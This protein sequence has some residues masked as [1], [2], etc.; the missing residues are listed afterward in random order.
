MFFGL[1]HDLLNYSVSSK[2]VPMNPLRYLGSSIDETC[3]TDSDLLSQ[4][5]A[6]LD[7][8]DLEVYSLAYD[9]RYGTPKDE[10]GRKNKGY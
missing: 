4:V 3:T 8:G 5:C 9:R 10:G 2:G 1:H 6:I 7:C